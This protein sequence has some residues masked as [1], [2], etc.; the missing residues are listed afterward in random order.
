M[1]VGEL[2]EFALIEL[3]KGIVGNPFRDDV[4]LGIGD[5]TSVWRTQNGIQLGTTD[6]LIQGVHFTLNNATWH[7]LG[8]KALAV[9]LS[10]IA[11]MG[12]EPSYALISLGLPPQIEVDDVVALYRGLKEIAGEFNV[13]ICGG[14]LSNAPVVMIS[15]SLIGTASENFLVR[16]SA[17]PGDQIAVTGCL[18]QAA[19][20]LKMLASGLEFEP[21]TDAYFRK[22]HFR[23]YPR[24]A[25]GRIL[26]Q[27][28][29][30]TAIDLSDGL[31]SDLTHIARA[32]NVGAKVYIQN[33]PVHP[34]VKTAFSTEVSSLALSGG[35]DY[36]LLFTAKSYVINRVK[37]LI[38]VPVTVIGEVTSDE[39]GY[40][41][42]I[43]EKGSDI[44]WSQYGWEHFKPL[45]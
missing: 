33:L 15:V 7:D 37:T 14:N 31:V 12:G 13:D 16:S 42:L 17:S 45:H 27:Q 44:E 10:D 25:E 24:I 9:N 35:E 21:G 39:P 23:P 29:V 40:V 32:S 43:D 34:L 22:A 18:G 3:I 30:K 28:G 1:N 4:I 5:D 19:A 38:K 6:S 11:A 2:G 8:W 26:V 20:G 41:K 36:E